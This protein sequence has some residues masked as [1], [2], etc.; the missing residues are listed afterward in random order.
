MKDGAQVGASK[1]GKTYDYDEEFAK[2]AA[3]VFGEL[4][5]LVEGGQ[6]QYGLAEF[7]YKDVYN[8]ERSAD[9]NSCFSDIFYTKKQNWKMPGSIEAIFRGPSADFNGS[10]WNT[11]KVFGPKVDKVVG[12]DS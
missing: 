6:T 8:H 10:N 9:A 2:K 5:T 1:N 4:L 7:K 12:H 3:E 11:S